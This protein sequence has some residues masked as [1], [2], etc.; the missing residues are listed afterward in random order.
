MF[1]S[2]CTQK[3]NDRPLKE[4][5]NGVKWNR[6]NLKF[7]RVIYDLVRH[8]QLKFR[9]EDDSADASVSKNRIIDLLCLFISKWEEEKNKRKTQHSAHSCDEWPT[10]WFTSHVV[11]NIKSCCIVSSL[12]WLIDDFDSTL[13]VSNLVNMTTPNF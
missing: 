11:A 12:I 3:V 8:P 4:L 5:S 13:I 6:I 2:K 1:W 9:K 10:F 7:T